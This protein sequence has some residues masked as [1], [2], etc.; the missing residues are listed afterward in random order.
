[1]II[2]HEVVSLSTEVRVV[3]D[4]SLYRDPITKI[5]L[6]IIDP[7]NGNKTTVEVANIDSLIDIGDCIKALERELGLE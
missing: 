1:M 6:V 5:N 7:N 3:K 2:T 4:G